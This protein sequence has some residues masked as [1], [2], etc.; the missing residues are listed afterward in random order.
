MLPALVFLPLGVAFLVLT[1][2]AWRYGATAIEWFY[3]GQ[4]G[5]LIHFAKAYAAGISAFVGTR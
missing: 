1:R 5:C 4:P 2:F 3:P